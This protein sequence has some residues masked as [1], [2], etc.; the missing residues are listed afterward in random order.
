MTHFSLSNDMILS[1][2]FLTISRRL[3]FFII[4]SVIELVNGHNDD[5]LWFSHL[6]LELTAYLVHYPRL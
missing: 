3:S 2:V 6:I 4:L 5:N 1:L